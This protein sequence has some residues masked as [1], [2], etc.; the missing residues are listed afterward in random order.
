MCNSIRLC[1]GLALTIWLAGCA[2]PNSIVRND[3][4][5]S[6]EPAIENPFVLPIQEA[7]PPDIQSVRLY[8]RGSTAN[9]PIIK[10]GTNETLILEFDYLGE[11]NKQYRAEVT[12]YNRDWSESALLPD[13]YL[14]GFSTT[15]IN[16]GQKSLSQRPSYFHYSFEFPNSQLSFKISGNYLLSVYDYE[17]D[18]LLFS[19][20]FFIHE[21]EG[22]LKTQTEEIF[23]QSRGLSRQHQLFSY[24]SYPSFVEIPQFDLNFVYVQNQF[25]G[26]AKEVDFF[27]T[28]SPGQV[29]FQLSQDQAFVSD[30]TF[31]L[32]D[33]STLTAD[34]LQILSIEE[35]TIPPKVVLQRDVQNLD[36]SPNLLPDTRFGLPVDDRNAAY[37]EVHFRLETNSQVNPNTKVFLVGGFSGWIIDRRNR[38]QFDPENNWWEG[39]A[40]IKQGQYAYKYVIVDQYTI[41][42]LT[43]D[44]GLFS[45]RQQYLT[46]VYFRDPTRN[47]DRLLQVDQIISR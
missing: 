36:P 18:E 34:G 13:F 17:T 32:L 10:L 31:K 39:H 5:R 15:Y 45:T 42:D 23:A 20:P 24:F 29:H 4:E 35:D 33:L 26:R 14:S 37:A 6:R 7:P 22:I 38:M 46:L 43:L 40:L 16:T 21:G 27:D 8:R 47:Y 41:D 2:I 25:W 19:L 3:P 9:S 11:T 30:Y 1:I 12:H 44:Q 28:S